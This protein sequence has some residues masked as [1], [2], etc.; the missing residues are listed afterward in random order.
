M[1]VCLRGHKPHNASHRPSP[2]PRVRRGKIVTEK[3]QPCDGSHIFLF[4]IVLFPHRDASRRQ[5]PPASLRRRAPVSCHRR[6]SGAPPL[7]YFRRQCVLAGL[8][9]PRPRACSPAFRGR[10]RVRASPRPP[11][12]FRRRC[13]CSLASHR[14]A[15]VR[16]SPR[17]PPAFR[18]RCVCSLASHRRARTRARRRPSPAFRGRAHPAPPAARACAPLLLSLQTKPLPQAKRNRP[19]PST[20]TAAAASSFRDPDQGE[21]P[22]PSRLSSCLLSRRSPPRCPASPWPRVFD[23]ICSDHT[24]PDDDGDGGCRRETWTRRSSRS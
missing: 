13:V 11:P 17:P 10:A 12:A 1:L 14:R 23:P 22:S 9:W 5:T 20:T 16:A 3:K 4:P 8:P 6:P 7:Q 18:R 19:P 2:T 24:Y 15:R 21:P